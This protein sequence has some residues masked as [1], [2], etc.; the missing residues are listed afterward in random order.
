MQAVMAARSTPLPRR[1]LLSCT[2]VI[3][4]LIVRL[5][6]LPDLAEQ[7]TYVPFHIA[8]VLAAIFGGTAGCLTAAVLSVAAA[9][10]LFFSLDNAVAYA[11]FATFLGTAALLTLLE[12]ALLTAQHRWLAAQQSL[13]SDAHLRLFIEQAPV[14]MAMLC[15]TSP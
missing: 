4:A 15:I 10:S 1:I 11:M 9:H 14:S 6:I 12:E 13:A 8:V 2:F 5:T 3:A 7:P